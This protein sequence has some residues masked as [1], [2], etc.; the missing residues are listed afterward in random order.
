M[1]MLGSIYLACGILY[2]LWNTRSRFFQ[3]YM[4]QQFALGRW[5]MPA[6]SFC[7]G[8][9]V[10]PVGATVTLAWFLARGRRR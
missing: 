2:C 3:A 10:W 4:A 5:W 1:I 7:A 6:I 8:V 9:L